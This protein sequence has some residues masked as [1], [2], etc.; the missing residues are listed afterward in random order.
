MRLRLDGKDHSLPG[1]YEELGPMIDACLRGDLNGSETGPRVASR[2]WLDGVLV[3]D[4]ARLET[5]RVEGVASIEVETRAVVDVAIDAIESAASYAAQL[6]SALIVAA[7]HFRDGSI[8][9]ASDHFTS[10]LDGL[11][12]LLE[13]VDAVAGV[14]RQA[15]SRASMETPLLPLLCELE[16]CQAG[17]DWLALADRLEYEVAPLVATW[18]AALRA[19]QR[20]NGASGDR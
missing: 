8:E 18:P 16:P 10:C 3:D 6:A 17:E 15:V 14:G 19:T 1:G 5:R 9:V 11:S 7:G 20:A 13:V 4:F 12:L 2:I